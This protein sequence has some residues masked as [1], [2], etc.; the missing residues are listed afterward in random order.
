MR[1][2]LLGGRAGQEHVGD[3]AD[4]VLGDL[5]GVAGLDVELDLFDSGV[6]RDIRQGTEDTVLLGGE[7]ADRRSLASGR[8]GVGAPAGSGLEIGARGVDA[9]GAVDES[10]DVVAGR[11]CA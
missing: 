6:L 10:N 7:E 1:V 5:D 2:D 3:A 11:A 8:V 9:G 4:V